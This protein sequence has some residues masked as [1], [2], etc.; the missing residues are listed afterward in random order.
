MFF[1]DASIGTNGSIIETEDTIGTLNGLAIYGQTEGGL[2]R[3]THGDG[4][5][6]FNVF[7][8]G[9]QSGRGAGTDWGDRHMSGC[10]FDDL[11]LDP[12]S[13]SLF[14]T[15]FGVTIENCLFKNVTID[16]EQLFDVSDAAAWIIRNNIFYNI[17][18]E[19]GAGNVIAINNI[20]ASAIV[21]TI[22]DNSLLWD[23]PSQWDGAIA[24][25]TDAT[26]NTINFGGNLI[27]GLDNDDGA[28]AIALDLHSTI[29]DGIVYRNGRNNCISAVVVS[30]GGTMEFVDDVG[31]YTTTPIIATAP[32]IDAIS[33]GGGAKRVGSYLAEKKCGAKT[34]AQQPGMGTGHGWL[35]ERMG[36]ER[37]NDTIVVKSKAF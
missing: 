20:A 30:G 22:E 37:P 10:D 8:R 35:Y 21:H 29:I 7:G 26:T 16:E 36:I 1:T 34:G 3:N 33:L 31:D 13:G 2:T 12:G 14:G 18:T 6:M 11:Y 15:T 9:V 27:D 25:D 32:D 5:L 23:E 17:Q 28:T 19:D 4:M 24:T